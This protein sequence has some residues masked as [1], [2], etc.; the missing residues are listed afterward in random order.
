MNMNCCSQEDILILRTFIIGDVHGCDEQL[1]RIMRKLQPDSETDRIIMLGDLFDRGPDSWG[2]F[3]TVQ[4]LADVYGDRFI[5][6]RGNHED[7]LLRRDMS[8][9]DNLIWIR[10]G[11]R[12]TVKS[13]SRHGEKMEETIPWLTEHTVLYYKAELFQC[14]HA[15]IKVEPIEAN[16]NYTLVHDHSVVTQNVYHG[17]LTITGHIALEKPYWFSGDGKNAE[18]IPYGRH[19]PLPGYGVICIDTGC[20]KGGELTAMVVED[21]Y[22]TLFNSV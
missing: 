11:K 6:L 14:V 4:K 9:M 18:E 2:V 21:G 12:D 1:K 13:F 3:Q 7:Y 8:F 10:V 17:F 15:G 19:C 22:Y 20:G 16:D 5:L